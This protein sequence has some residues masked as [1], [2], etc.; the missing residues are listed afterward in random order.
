M[1]KKL[2][3][4]GYRL[5]FALL[6]L[7]A[8]ATQLVYGIRHTDGFSTVNFFSFFTIESNLIGAITFVVGALWLLLGWTRRRLD[9]L[10]GA[11][12]L[13]MVVT[14]IVYA[15][16]LSNA[17]VQTAIPWVNAVLHYLFP[18]GMLLDWLLDCPKQLS[19]KRALLWLI[20]P[21]AYLAYTL[22]RGP[23]A[24]HWY[25]YPFLNVSG[26]GYT[27]V[28][29]SSLVIALAVVGLAFG[30]IRLTYLKRLQH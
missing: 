1:D 15:V 13:Y 8:V 28:A 10:R 6:V 11:A 2:V 12:T 18:A 30:L 23:F 27:Y 5:A 16:L 14:G 24:H 22:I 4:T 29:F 7:V 19:F 26:H 25:P 9:Y 17:D 20:Y 3:L 21:L